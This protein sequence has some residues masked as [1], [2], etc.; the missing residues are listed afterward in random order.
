MTTS[1]TTTH[2]EAHLQVTKYGNRLPGECIPEF[3]V[4]VLVT[5]QELGL[6]GEREQCSVV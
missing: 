6:G 3:Q 2:M 1:S 4:A 5:N